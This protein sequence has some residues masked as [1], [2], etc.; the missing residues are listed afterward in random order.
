MNRPAVGV[1]IAL[2]LVL[3]APLLLLAAPSALRY[4]VLADVSSNTELDSNG[5]PLTR[6]VAN[7]TT[8]NRALLEA[9]RSQWQA[10]GLSVEVANMPWDDYLPAVAHGSAR[11]RILAALETRVCAL[12]TPTVPLY[13]R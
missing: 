6:I 1:R 10:P 11:W 2:L 4:A 13:W 3:A 5:L 12:E 9:F 7:T 8:D